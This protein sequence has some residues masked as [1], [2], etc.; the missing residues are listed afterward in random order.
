MR[1]GIPNVRVASE[2]P[3]AINFQSQMI[4]SYQNYYDGYIQHEEIKY[5][6]NS[7]INK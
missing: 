4:E 7:Y 3:E 1:N 2:R 5:L 6:L